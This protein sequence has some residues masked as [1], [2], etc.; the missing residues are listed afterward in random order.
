LLII[1]KTVIGFGSP[2]GGRHQAESTGKEGRGILL[3]V[4]EPLGPSEVYG[5]D[6]LFVR[7]LDGDETHDAALAALEAAGHPV[8][9]LNL[10]DHPYD[11]GG[12]FF[13]WEMATAVASH[14]L[15]INPFDQPNVEAAKVLA[16]QMV[17]E[18][19]E[20]GALPGGESA[21]LTV[22]VRPTAQ[23]RCRKWPLHPVHRRR[24]ARSI[25]S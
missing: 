1:C 9:R 14:R 22:E 17:A 23:G 2:A 19:T 7:I 24:P 12:Q 8:V 11:L 18:Y 15:G 5:N 20:K 4:R 10:H 25:H 13:L 6:R 3:V 21:S 16:R